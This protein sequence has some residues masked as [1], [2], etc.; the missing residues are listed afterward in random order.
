MGG[1]NAPVPEPFVRSRF[2]IAQISFS[3]AA[4]TF[5]Q[6]PDFRHLSAD[7]QSNDPSFGI[8]D[9]GPAAVST[10]DGTASA[11]AIDIPKPGTSHLVRLLDTRHLLYRTNL[12]AHDESPIA[13]P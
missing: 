9:R 11:L 3:L 10:T 13:G 5:F 8:D 2:G 6:V 1:S 7:A 4:H 12:G